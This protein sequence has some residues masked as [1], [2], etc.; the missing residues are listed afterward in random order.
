[1]NTENIFI[2]RVVLSFFIAGGWIAFS[3]ILAERFGSKIGGLISNLPSNILVSLIFI[4]IVNDVNYVGNLVPAVPIGLII[5][6]FFLIVFI[7][8]LRFNLFI[9]VVTSL[10]VWFLSAFIM[11]RFELN[12][13]TVNILI[14]I[15]VIVIAVLFLEK[16]V[17]VKSQQN[18]RKRYSA[19]QII[20]RTVFGGGIVATIVVIS[21]YC[22]PYFTGIF[23]TFPAMLL[24]TLILL[25]LNQSKEFAMATGKVLILSLTNIIVYVLFVSLTYPRIGI[26]LGTIVSYVLSALWIT[27]LYPV[28]KRMV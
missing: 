14:C 11:P 9:S 8:L 16:V 21:K 12:N 20:F 13:L 26:L 19:G 3:T 17:K 22:S 28:V 7:I 1:M 6:V 10:F 18:H 27:F 2:I 4:S 5:D 25:S 15:L 24:S 23:S